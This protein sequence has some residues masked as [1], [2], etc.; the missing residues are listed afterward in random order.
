M[1][2]LQPV[3]S[4][5]SF[6][7]ASVSYLL[8]HSRREAEARRRG[9]SLDAM[10]YTPCEQ[11]IFCT[12]SILEGFV[13]PMPSQEYFYYLPDS[14]TYSIIGKRLQNF[15]CQDLLSEKPQESVGDR[16]MKLVV[17]SLVI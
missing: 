6:T 17:D 5:Q 7:T 8:H 16:A 2:R 4:W 3:Q 14:Q 10:E 11:P 15:N 9:I 12:C 1:H 13:R